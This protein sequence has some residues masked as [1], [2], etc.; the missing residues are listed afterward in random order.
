MCFGGR[1]LHGWVAVPS[2][3]TFATHTHWHG[4]ITGGQCGDLPVR[5][6]AVSAELKTGVLAKR[7]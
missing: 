2:W 5:P 4:R 6:M 7:A 1:G 3:K